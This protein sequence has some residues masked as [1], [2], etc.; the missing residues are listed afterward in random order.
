[1]IHIKKLFIKYENG[2]PYTLNNIYVFTESLS[3]QN[4]LQDWHNYTIKYKD[5]IWAITKTIKLYDVD[6]F[7][8]SPHKNSLTRLTNPKKNFSVRT[9][10]KLASQ[11]NKE[12]RTKPNPVKKSLSPYIRAFHIWRSKQNNMFFTNPKGNYWVEDDDNK[13]LTKGSVFK[14]YEDD[15]SETPMF[16]LI[17][18]ELKNPQSLVRVY[19]DA[20]GKP[21]VVFKAKPEKLLGV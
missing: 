5:N 14:L 18:G 13:Y 11:R 7:E 1:M 17:K 20:D 10:I 9:D 3:D 21:F 2:K 19:S 15:K 12:N 6:Y 8:L 16:A 4:L